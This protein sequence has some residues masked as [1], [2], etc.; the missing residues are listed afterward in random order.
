MVSGW[1]SAGAACW[2]GSGASDAFALLAVSARG[3][4][5]CASTCCVE[6]ER[7]TPS[8]NEV[9]SPQYLNRRTATTT[10]NTKLNMQDPFLTTPKTRELRIDASGHDAESI[11]FVY[12]DLGALQ[13]DPLLTSIWKQHLRK[14]ALRST[15]GG[16]GSMS[17]VLVN[18][19]PH[20]HPTRLLFKQVG[21][22]WLGTHHRARGLF[23][24]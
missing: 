6:S 16:M 21:A 1:R 7:I 18:P 10:L 13:N 24:R 5:G 17:L 3:A 22:G 19:H 15:L 2:F 4:S 23:H 9:T 14:K 8:R 12:L 20:H 11:A